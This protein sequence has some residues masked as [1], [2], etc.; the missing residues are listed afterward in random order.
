VNAAASDGAVWTVLGGPVETM[1]VAAIVAIFAWRALRQLAPRLHRRLVDG[2]R[3][4]LGLK[5]A[6]T[7]AADCGSGCGS[8]N[9]C[10][11]AA[12]PGTADTRPG[13][14]PLVFKPRKP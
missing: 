2:L 6:A 9:N 5:V 1:V 12:A 7:E 14:A 10:G 11:P 3:R 4:R 13:E 8:C